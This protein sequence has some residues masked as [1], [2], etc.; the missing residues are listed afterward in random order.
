MCLHI[1]EPLS[2]IEYCHV[3]TI[4]TVHMCAWL[5]PTHVTNQVPQFLYEAGYGCPAYPELSGAIAI[6]QPRRVAAVSTAERVA[7]ELSSKVG[8]LVGYQVGGGV[9]KDCSMYTPL[10]ANSPLPTIS[11]SD[12]MYIL[13]MLTLC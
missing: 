8:E 1:H 7:E 4:I 6:T 13:V 9:G 5:T 2:D 11:W 12:G 3:W 10:F